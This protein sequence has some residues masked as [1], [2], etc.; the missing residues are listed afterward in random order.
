MP[1][2]NFQP[3]VRQTRMNQSN[4]INHNH[5]HS[6]T[7]HKIIEILK[8]ESKPA[9][10]P[11]MSSNN[12][13]PKPS[14]AVS[15]DSY[16]N[17]N[18][19]KMLSLVSRTI[20][21]GDD[22]QNAARRD[23]SQVDR[24]VEMHV[25]PSTAST[26]GVG[27][28]SHISNGRGHATATS[29]GHQHH[30]PD[31]VLSSSA[32]MSKKSPASG[33]RKYKKKRGEMTAQELAEA[34]RKRK[35]ANV[36]SATESRQRRR[37][38]LEQLRQEAG[39]LQA[40]NFALIRENQTLE[41]CIKYYNAIIEKVIQGAEIVT[42]P[43]KING[44]AGVGS[45]ST[46]PVVNNSTCNMANN[47]SPSAMPKPSMLQMQ[48]PMQVQTGISPQMPAQYQ[49]TYNTAMPPTQPFLWQ[50][51]Q[52]QQQVQQQIPAGQPTMMAPQQSRGQGGILWA[53]HDQQQQSQ[54]QIQSS[55]PDIFMQMAAI[56]LNQAHQQ[57]IQQ[58]Q[59]QQQQQH[60]QV[61]A[62]APTPS[63]WSQF[64]N[65]EAPVINPTDLA[66]IDANALI[67]Q[68]MNIGSPGVGWNNSQQ[69]PQAT[70]TTTL[71]QSQRPFFPVSAPQPT[72]VGYKQ[73][74]TLATPNM[75]GTAA[76]RQSNGGQVQSTIPQNE[77]QSMPSFF[78][79]GGIHV[80]QNDISTTQQED[81]SFWLA[82][83]QSLGL[84]DE[85]RINLQDDTHDEVLDDDL[86]ERLDGG[87]LDYTRKE[88]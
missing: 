76:Y 41:Y 51:Q 13:H 37:A 31:N 84:P 4:R 48:T 12:E 33:K 44:G 86:F 71:T 82:Q 11:N 75:D 30:A 38:Q 62:T 2:F 36:K 25:I 22:E 1:G 18:D 88:E 21:G 3:A 68:I 70:A 56:L 66:Q 59:I 63:P 78:P 35:R 16:S 57:Q 40:T 54:Q 24:G 65:G 45:L 39:E 42:D 69:M 8:T 7:Y 26:S 50:N 6:I 73:P 5:R 34:D 60:N 80:P 29:S 14:G 58:R 61:V 23:R 28:K 77:A 55:P 74:S 79:T 52:N 10:E 83:L 85:I 15:P 20:G 32:S 87:N 64:P 81:P 67:S 43:S 27:T 49:E 72:A 53:Q 47:G 19:A 17:D 9:Q 46:M